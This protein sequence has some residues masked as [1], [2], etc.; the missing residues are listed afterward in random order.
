MNDPAQGLSSDLG[1]IEG[2]LRL[3]VDSH[4][5]EMTSADQ[6]AKSQAV[7]SAEVAKVQNALKARK[8]TKT[9]CLSTSLHATASLNDHCLMLR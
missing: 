6:V 4:N 1:D 5:G 2:T 9:G 8:R 3:D 7:N